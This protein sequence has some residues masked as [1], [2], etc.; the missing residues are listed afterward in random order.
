MTEY[1]KMLR[2]E[3]YNAIDESLLKDLNECKDRCW[4]YNRIRPTLIRERNQK[5]HEILGTCDEETFIN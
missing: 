1:D 5:L 4:E 2:G 3:V